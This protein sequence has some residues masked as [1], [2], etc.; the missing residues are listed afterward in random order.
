[1]T[2]NV[3]FYQ[4]LSFFADDTSLYSIVEDPIT[5][6]TELNHDLGTF[7]NWAWAWKMSFNPDPTKP[8][9][10]I[11]FSHKSIKPYHPPLFINGLEVKRVNEHT[12]L[13]LILDSKLSLCFI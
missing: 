11:L 10:E 5:S 6:A 9:E 7:S 4:K 8:A 13:G 1:M 3:E 2:L 12:H